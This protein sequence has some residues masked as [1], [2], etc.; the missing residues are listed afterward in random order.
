[1]PIPLTLRFFH[2]LFQRISKSMGDKAFHVGLLIVTLVFWLMSGRVREHLWENIFPWIVMLALMVLRDAVVSARALW[3]EVSDERRRLLVRESGILLPSGRP[4]TVITQSEPNSRDG[5][6]ILGMTIILSILVLLAVYLTWQKARIANAPST[7]FEAG[8]KSQLQDTEIYMVCTRTA[9]PIHIAAGSVAHVKT[10]NK[11][12]YVNTQWAM[13]D[14]HN[15][16][17]KE[18][19]WP[20][21]KIMKSGP[22][23]NPGVFGYKCDVTNHATTNLIDLAIPLSTNFGNEKPPLTY[24]AV[25]SPLDAGTTFSF[26]MI[27]ECPVEVSVIAPDTVSVQVFGE[28]QRRTVP[29]H[30]SHR[31]PIEQIMIFFPSKVRWTGNVCE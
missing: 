7:P 31:N 21:E 14:I 25:I 15:D 1:M 9:L 13:D 30:W 8:A 24:L 11:K 3:N 2:L 18:R 17:T 29:L 28:D 12:Q 22:K 23:F 27:N 6:K 26:Y 20:D 16:E 5:V 4:A 19:L 10:F